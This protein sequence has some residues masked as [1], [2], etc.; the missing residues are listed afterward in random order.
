MA[1]TYKI[2]E[3]GKEKSSIVYQTDDWYDALKWI[4]SDAHVHHC[5][6]YEGVEGMSIADFNALNDDPRWQVK[7]KQLVLD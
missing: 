7:V 1:I 4:T 5:I 6:H 3:N 2:T